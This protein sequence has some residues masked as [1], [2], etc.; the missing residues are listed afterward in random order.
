MAR[1]Q[2]ITRIIWSILNSDLYSLMF[3]KACDFNSDL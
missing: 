3:Y 1:D 2:Q